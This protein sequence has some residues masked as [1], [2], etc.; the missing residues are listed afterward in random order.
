MTVLNRNLRVNVRHCVAGKGLSYCQLRQ[1]L[2]VCLQAGRPTLP[3]INLIIF[4]V[5]YDSLSPI[6]VD[7]ITNS[8]LLQQYYKEPHE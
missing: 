4:K 6:V 7:I 8:P 3:A 2:T 5:V 1:V